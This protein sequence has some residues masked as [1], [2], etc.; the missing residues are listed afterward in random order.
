MMPTTILELQHISKRFENIQ[1]LDNVSFDLREGETHALV[2]ENGA[3]KSTLMK[4][5]AG[6]YTGYEGQ[7]LLD[8]KAI[9]LQSPRDALSRG[10]GMI[11]QE[12][13]VMPELTVA[14]NL[15]LGRQLTN[16]FGAV[17][18]GRMNRI[19]VEELSKLGFDHID[20]R[21]P[22][23]NYS[24]GTQQ[25]VEVLRAILSG[26]RVLIM[27]EPTT[28]LSPPEVERLIQL[29]DTLRAQ[30][31]S[32][33]YISHFL[34]E[35]MRVA[36]R[37]TVLRDGHKVET[38]D[39]R[40]TNIENV[41]SLILGRQIEASLPAATHRSSDKP[42]LEITDLTADVFTG[43]NLSVGHGEVVGLYGAI[44]AGH[45]D[46]AR[47]LFGLY[48]LDSGGIRL[49]GKAFPARFSARYAIQHGIAYATE[50]RRQSLFMEEP[51]YRNVMMPHLER[52]GR[53]LAPGKTV[54]LAKAAPQIELTGVHPAD[55]LNPVGQL[56]GGNQQK[57][58]IARWLPFPPKLFVM[59]E[60]TRGMDV[61]A[62]SEVL[63]I[64]RNFR[65]QGYGVL[66]VSSEPETVLS[67]SDRI[68]VMSRGKVVADLQNE[69]LDKDVLMRLL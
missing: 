28:A 62:K 24:L 45:F 6:L 11:H 15:F 21:A 18:W 33:I 66:V 25:V 49:D 48:R 65:N 16:S 40:T 1:A 50:S 56:S 8:G 19:A 44:G 5:L 43:V 17:N 67:V 42:L 34:E 63:A 12:L 52:M 9:Q 57:V 64:L 38:L 36:D 60:P 27:D 61:G 69:K 54:E 4:I 14:E 10:I 30:K 47:A 58:A 29:I 7:F 59:A 13:S 68:V 35:V 39:K 22:L 3:G 23:G 31:R 51:I 26:A 55:P 2:G 20:V 53:L 37:I 32:I 41:I 46:L